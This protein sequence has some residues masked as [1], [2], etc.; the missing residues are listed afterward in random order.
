MRNFHTTP[1][2]STPQNTARFKHILEI[3][4]RR[5]AQ[6]QQRQVGNS[7]NENAEFLHSEWT[8]LLHE[9]TTKYLIL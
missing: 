4:A 2:T 5:P 8:F 3:A 9:K 7:R 1:L 6:P